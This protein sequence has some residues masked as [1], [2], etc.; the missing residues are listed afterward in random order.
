MFLEK[1]IYTIEHLRI[2]FKKKRPT[3]LLTTLN[4]PKMTKKSVWPIQILSLEALFGVVADS[5][6]QL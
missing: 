2:I 3:G 5:P 4:L 1:M 6:E